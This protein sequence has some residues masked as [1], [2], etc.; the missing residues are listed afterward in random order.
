MKKSWI[1]Q[2]LENG[3]WNNDPFPHMANREALEEKLLSD[4]IRF[5]PDEQ[6]LYLASQ[7]KKIQTRHH[8]FLNTESISHFRS[9]TKR[10]FWRAF[11]NDI[12]DDSIVVKKKLSRLFYEKLDIGL[13]PP[14]K[15]FI[16]GLQNYLQ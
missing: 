8:A 5:F 2:L 1:L 3:D 12:V 10:A 4:V 11:L 9:G 14:E 13:I 7:T 16:G 6:D 15:I